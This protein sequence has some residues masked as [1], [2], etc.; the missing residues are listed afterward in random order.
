MTYQCEH[1]NLV[2]GTFLLRGEVSPIIFQQAMGFKDGGCALA[3]LNCDT[4]GKKKTLMNE[5][6]ATIWGKIDL[7]MCSVSYKQIF[8]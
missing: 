5:V 2:L 1:A 8:K 4:N 6:V 7:R 3:M